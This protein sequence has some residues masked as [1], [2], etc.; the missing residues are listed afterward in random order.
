MGIARRRQGARNRSPCAHYWHSVRAAA[1]VMVDR[2]HSI[3]VDLERLIRA[4][5][6]VLI[7]PADR[8][9]TR[10]HPINL[11]RLRPLRPGTENASVFLHRGGTNLI[12]NVLRVLTTG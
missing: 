10:T 2:A 12:S 8:I 5:L 1:E 4:V 9:D 11:P 3:I 7:Y 6:K